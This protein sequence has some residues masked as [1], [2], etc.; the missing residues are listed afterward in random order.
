MLFP[1]FIYYPT[2]YLF[3]G[4]VV[5]GHGHGE[6]VVWHDIISWLQSQRNVTGKSKSAPPPT[7]TLHW[8]AHAVA[9]ITL[10]PDGRYLF[11][12]GDEG[13][14]VV[15]QLGSNNKDFVP[16]LGAGITFLSSSA[17]EARVAV[18][19]ADNAV[20]IINTASMREDWEMRSL[21]VP[22]IESQSKR[23]ERK[24]IDIPSS[25]QQ[26]FT[27]S[28]TQ[29][30]SSY[31]C[32]IKVEG[33][34]GNISCNGYPGQLQMLDLT[35]QTFRTSHE[36][37]QFTRVSKKESYSKMTV[38]STM[39]YDFLNTSLGSLMVTLDV[40]RGEESDAEAS[41]KFWEWDAEKSKYRLSAQVDRPHGN[42][43]VTS[44]MFS[45][46][47]SQSARTTQQAL[48][49]VSAN[50]SSSSTLSFTCSCATAA[51]D[52][53][54]K[55]WIGQSHVSAQSQDDGLKSGGASAIGMH[56]TCSFSFKHRDCPAGAMSFSFDGSLL[57]AS[58][59]NVVTL[60]DPSQV[61]LLRSV[62]NPARS[63]IT[64]TAFIEPRASN[65]MGGGSGEAMLVVGS[66]RSLSVFDLMTM[67]LMWSVEGFFASFA[68]AADES[69]AIK[70]DGST[71]NKTSSF[72]WIAA[73]I[74][75][76]SEKYEFNHP[77]SDTV[78]AAAE[79]YKILLFSCY[80]SKPV[81]VQRMR[82]KTC[83]MTF[84]SNQKDLTSSLSSGLVVLT[85]QGELTIV[86][87]TEALK[88]HF[89]D[90]SQSSS[91]VV[92]AKVFGAKLPTL[93]FSAVVHSYNQSNGSEG[94]M[95]ISALI[96]QNS[97]SV[98]K[99]W[100]EGMFD[101]KSGSIP[102]LSAIYGE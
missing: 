83:S 87:S 72:A 31:R 53:S 57:A 5:T 34:S 42:A 14:L 60:W 13:V 74:N 4:L 73:S 11:S 37:V 85:M 54:I 9:S 68:V 63:D 67:K 23:Q 48:N 62:V 90:R 64:F 26:V 18:T 94:S 100:L 101:S 44:V 84:W 20:R 65:L 89:C 78:E 10:S 50:T 76:I 59:E 91:G 98:T 1:I 3:S 16:R 39:H 29:S 96:K 40:R 56:W 24:D 43:R 2:I 28:F 6:I 15:W 47:S 7:T 75:T 45:P 80:S 19:T 46:S 51:V 17:K 35:T 81:C 86:G 12:G 102:P 79:S 69:A 33:R 61:L 38:P 32:S 21:F 8:H 58:Y 49:A 92:Q 30:E 82:S 52:G 25:S 22:A 71:G 77:K 66:K 93:P 27:Q 36:I 55:I 95:P 88:Q 70:F 99:G 97:Q 41:L